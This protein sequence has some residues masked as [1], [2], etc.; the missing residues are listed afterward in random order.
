MSSVDKSQRRWHRRKADKPWLP[1]RREF[2]AGAGGTLLLP[3]LGSRARAGVLVGDAGGSTV[4]PPSGGRS[5]LN[6]V[7]LNIGGSFPFANAMKMGAN[8]SYADNSFPPEPDTLNDNGYPIVI[9]KGGVKC[10]IAIPTQAQRPGQYRLEFQGT[11]TVDGVNGTDV[12]V[13]RNAPADGDLSMSISSGT[14]ISN[15]SYVHQD[16]VS[17]YDAGN[18]FSNCFLDVVAPMNFGVVRFLDW[19]V[20]NPT[21]VVNWADRKPVDYAFYH[22]SQFRA[23]MWGGVTSHVVNGD[24]SYTFSVSAPPKW[25]GLVLRQQVIVRWDVTTPAFD[26]PCYMDVAG[27]GPVRML[28]QNGDAWFKGQQPTQNRYAMIT[29]DPDI[30]PEVSSDGIWMMQGGRRNNLLFNGVPPEVCF[31]LCDVLDA[32]AWFSAPPFALDPQTDY[33]EELATYGRDNHPNQVPRYEVSP[34][35]CWNTLSGFVGTI[36]GSNRAKTRWASSG[37]G[38]PAA[39]NE[40]VGMVSATGAKIVWDVYGGDTTKFQTLTGFKTTDGSTSTSIQHRIADG[41]WVT[42]SGGESAYLHLTHICTANYFAPTYSA[43][44]LAAAAAAYAAAPT[45]PEKD[46]I[47]LAY[48]KSCLVDGIGN[49]YKFSIPREWGNILKIHNMGKSYKPTMKMT[50]YEG[51]FSPPAY[52][53]DVRIDALKL[54]AKMLPEVNQI[55]YHSYVALEEQGGECPSCYYLSGPG[56]W[57]LYEIDIFDTPSPQAAAITAFNN[58]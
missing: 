44:Q 12:S 32:S 9:A 58:P 26:T 35:E 17:S 19:M 39:T 1:S 25:N 16:D 52:T 14:N 15:L 45:Q 55:L 10:A 37:L 57:S 31:K 43:A 5:Q 48:L 7:N 41:L 42:L 38:Q 29:Y 34:N 22:G 3:P 49:Q 40:W 8:W 27:T 2:M 21:N 20:L 13:L 56:I 36:Y 4:P 18:I 53:G 28:G 11:G 23:D 46:A 54:A 33:L 24:G 51:G 47:A 50:F 6:V 30:R